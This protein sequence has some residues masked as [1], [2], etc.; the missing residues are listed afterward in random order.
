MRYFCHVTQI[1]G[2]QDP[3]QTKSQFSFSNDYSLNFTA[4][5]D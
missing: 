5:K 3:L 2:Q 4:V 1:K